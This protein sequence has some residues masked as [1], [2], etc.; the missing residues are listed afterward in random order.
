LVALVAGHVVDVDG[1]KASVYIIVT[2][3]LNRV[4]AAILAILSNAFCFVLWNISLAFGLKI[5]QAG[6]T[7]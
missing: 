2:A 3:K 1:E 6:S 4:A 7:V 5:F